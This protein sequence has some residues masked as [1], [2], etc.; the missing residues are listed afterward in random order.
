MIQETS[1]QS[2][3]NLINSDK[4]GELQKRV[5]DNI[6]YLKSATDKEL[7]ESSTIPI[8]IVT[9]RRNELMHEGIIEEDLRRK[10]KITERMAIAWRL[11]LQK[12]NQTKLKQ[13]KEGL[14]SSLFTRLTKEID[15]CNHKQEKMILSHLN[16]LKI[17]DLRRR[18]EEFM[19]MKTFS[20]DINGLM[21]SLI[22]ELRDLE[23]KD[24]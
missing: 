17:A 22:T 15:R 5:L 7:S 23:K 11:K 18:L 2:Y 16:A 21:L 6:V 24:E 12:D 10:C 8:N 19:F 13:D 4:L 14:S 9:A 1:K 3:Y 20:N